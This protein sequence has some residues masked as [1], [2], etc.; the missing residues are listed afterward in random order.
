MEGKL[1]FLKSEGTSK[2]NIQEYFCF[3]LSTKVGNGDEIVRSFQLKV[4]RNGKEILKETIIL[5]EN[6][7]KI[8]TMLIKVPF[9]PYQTRNCSFF[10]YT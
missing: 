1:F 2:Q 6:P 4:V 7:Y 8:F 3:S 10:L 5:P 9:S